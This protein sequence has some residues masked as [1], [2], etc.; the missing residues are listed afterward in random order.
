MV[1]VDITRTNQAQGD[2]IA[3]C[4]APIVAECARCNDCRKAY[5]TRYANGCVLE[6]VSPSCIEIVHV[7]YSFKINDIVSSRIFL[8]KFH[9]TDRDGPIPENFL[10][11]LQIGG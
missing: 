6:K 4:D 9:L 1:C 3:W 8:F 7:P 10:D 11:A 2:T 5:E